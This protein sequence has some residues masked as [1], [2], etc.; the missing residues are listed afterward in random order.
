MPVLHFVAATLAACACLCANA[1]AQTQNQIES[2]IDEALAQ[3]A[4]GAIVLVDIGGERQV[5][6]RGVANLATGDSMADSDL[7]R[8]ASVGKIYTA[9]V[10]HRLIL[11]GEI[12]LDKTAVDYVD[13]SLLDGIANA[14]T[15]TIRQM[16]NH[17][18]GIP[19]YYDD[20]WFSGVDTTH[21][22]TA[23]RTLAYIHGW[24]AEF[25]P[26]EGYG[27]SNTNYQLLAVIAEAVTHQAMAELINTIIV[28]PLGLENTGYN[29]QFHAQ[30]RIHGYG[31][32]AG[33]DTDVY[34][35]QENN[36]PDGGVFATAEDLAI[37]L[38][39]VFSQTGVLADLGQSM[40]SE[41]LDRGDGNYRALGPN[42]I[43]HPT[44]INLVMH[45]GSISGYATIA[46]RLLDP[47][48]VVI[49]HLNKDRMDLASEIARGI[50]LSITTSD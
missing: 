5:F 16:L 22:N 28:E 26:G 11:D 33:P 49:V 48:I 3:G 43:E 13:A 10:I 31:T 20:A 35:L 44:G 19:D 24:P 41:R 47:E 9:A 14:D 21:M 2:L 42:Y 45:A 7:L 25:A 32:D 15:A 17:S 1:S 46:V 40:L 12:E 34:W 30:D 39:A 27:Y 18:S 6:S 8:V 4:P 38:D 23:E 37:F 29:I 36:G 50:L